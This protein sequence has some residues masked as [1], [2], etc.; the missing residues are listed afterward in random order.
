MHIADV[1]MF[2]TQGGG[3]VR[4]YLEAKH[5]GLA[6][7]AKHSLVV[8]G[9]RRGRNNYLYSVPA[10]ML[11]FGQGYRFPLGKKIWVD[12]LTRIGPDLIE[13]GD[14]YVT[15][16]ASIDAGQR[17]GAPVVGFYHSDLTRMMHSG[18]D[19]GRTRCR[20]S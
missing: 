1:T 19:T 18:L 4:T 3:G 8:P 6:G 16:W 10:A 11:P 20:A 12:T 17:L 7:R 15:S 13:A 14:P 9:L 2:Y 5:R